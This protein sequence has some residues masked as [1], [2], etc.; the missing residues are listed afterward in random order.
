LRNSL[1]I[2]LVITLLFS[3]CAS[4]GVPCTANP[5]KKLY[6]AESLFNDLDRPLPAQS[7]I[8]E[9][10]E[11]YRKRNDLLGLAIAYQTYGDFLQSPTVGRW[12]KMDFS[13]ETIT[14]DNRYR[15]A[16]E[17]YEKSLKIAKSIPD[18][19][20]ASSAYFSIGRLQFLHFGNDRESCKNFSKSIEEHLIFR[21]AHPD[22]SV[23]LPKGYANFMDYVTAARKQVGC[24]K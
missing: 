1:Y 15:K 20:L 8:E 3:G 21:E 23:V 16:L 2:I 17:Y 22:E 9:A 7:L 19:A 14:H 5:E 12:S 24:L 6:Y 4:V 13:D 10:I 11:M 18:H